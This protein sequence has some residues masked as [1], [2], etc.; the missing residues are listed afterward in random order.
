MRRGCFEDLPSLSRI[1]AVIFGLVF[2]LACADG[3]RPDHVVLI[4]IDGFRPDFYQDTT[5]PAPMIQ[6]M[7]QEGA[8]V[9]AVRGVFPSVTYPSHTSMITGASP[10]RH[11]IYYNTPFEPGGQS[12]RWY[13]HTSAIRVPTLWHAVRE[14]GLKSASI[15]W[16]VSV[17]G[18]IDWNIPE[19]WSLEP[20]VPALDAIRSVTHPPELFEEVQREATGPFTDSDFEDRLLRDDRIGIA[21]AYLLEQYRP[22]LLTVH[23]IAVDHFQHESGR[24]AP[25]V[26]RALSTADQAVRHIVEAAERSGIQGRTAF[27]VTGDHG[28][29]DR[30]KLV[31]PNV[32]L[33]EAGMMEARHDRGDWRA[34]FHRTG[35][36]VFLHLRHPEDGE[37]VAQVRALLT[38]LPEDTQRLFRVIE[39]DEL[40]RLGA[41]PAVPLALSAVPGTSFSASFRP[42]AIREAEG[43]NHGH[44]PDLPQVHTG[45]IGWGSGFRSGEV[46][47]ST[48]IADLA[49]LIAE[50]LGIPFEAPDGISPRSLL[51]VQN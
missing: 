11:G 27:I 6:Q 48:E 46:V 45:L 5:W 51:A 9:K 50:L 12:G 43:G 33:V 39:R 17:G 3:G 38:R 19:F 13:W 32:W 15:S 14:A 20:D 21:A 26:R 35:G 30:D 8:Q 4:S 36:S 47:S 28:F 31:A 44:F 2:S 49:P 41:D 16:P 42:P 24:D 34:A 40:D 1:A 23:L 37:A 7:A 25:M 18:P 10:R 29:V 22:S